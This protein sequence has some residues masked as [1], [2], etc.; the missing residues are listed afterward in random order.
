MAEKKEKV[1]LFQ[2]KGYRILSKDNYNVVLEV[3][4]EEK[5]Y[6]FVGYYGDIPSAL[7]ALVRR[8]LLINRHVKHDTMSY[9]KEIIRYKQQLL[10]EIDDHFHPVDDELFN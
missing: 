10:Q 9:I 5:R 8:D 1:V 3:L 6:S 4:N 2:G 7:K